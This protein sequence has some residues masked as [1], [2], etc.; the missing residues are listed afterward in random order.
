MTNTGLPFLK[1]DTF[2]NNTTN[3]HKIIEHYAKQLGIL[4][5][6]NEESDDTFKPFKELL[7]GL[8]TKNPK[9]KV[10][11]VRTVCARGALCFA[12]GCSEMFFSFLGLAP[13]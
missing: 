10:E 1:I 3:A 12:S 11:R 6:S 2:S 8:A 7:A 4:G 9:W 5:M 13:A